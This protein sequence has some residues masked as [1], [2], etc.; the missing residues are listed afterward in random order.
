[1]SEDNNLYVI[2]LA[3]KLGWDGLA[4]ALVY[5]S[6]YKEAIELTFQYIEEDAPDLPVKSGIA[7]D[8][9]V[10]E[11]CS[12]SAAYVAELLYELVIEA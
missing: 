5:A 8:F 3:N 4:I 11:C 2:T 12:S 7:E 6:S 1:M 9:S 10:Y